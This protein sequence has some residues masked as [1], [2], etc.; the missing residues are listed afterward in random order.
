MNQPIRSV[1]PFRCN[2][3]SDEWHFAPDC[4]FWPTQVYAAELVIPDNS[5][6]CAE[7]IELQCEA[8]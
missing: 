1:H 8:A 5:H 3:G 7:C 2:V 4:R 6:A